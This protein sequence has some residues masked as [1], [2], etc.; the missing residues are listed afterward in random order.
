MK[1][2]AVALK[3]ETGDSA[4]KIVAK[5]TSRLAELIIKIARE[6]NIV[7]KENKLLSEVLM[8]FDAGDYVPEETYEVVAQILAFVFKLKIGKYT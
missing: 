3:Y 2:S 1:K 8:Q 7:I 4:P 5:G 6:N